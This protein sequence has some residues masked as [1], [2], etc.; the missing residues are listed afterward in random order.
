MLQQI[1]E[2]HRVK[3]ICDVRYV[4]VYAEIGHNNVGEIDFE[5]QAKTVETVSFVEVAF[6][7]LKFRVGLVESCQ[8]A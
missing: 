5:I 2:K 8:D 1:I 4:T 7:C 6:I 3:D